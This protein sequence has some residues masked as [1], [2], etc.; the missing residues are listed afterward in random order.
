MT[1]VV[2]PV[3]TAVLLLAPLAVAQGVGGE[4]YLAPPL[5]ASAALIAATPAAP[6]ARPGAVGFGHAVSVAAGLLVALG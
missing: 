2:R 5:A 4:P 3:V 1:P 6:A